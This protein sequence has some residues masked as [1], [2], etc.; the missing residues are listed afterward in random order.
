MDELAKV[1][2]GEWDAQAAGPRKGDLSLRK[3]RFTTSM[4]SVLRIEQ[5]TVELSLKQA[6]QQNGVQPGSA[7][8]Y[9]KPNDFVNLE[10]HIQ[11]R[12]RECTS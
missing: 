3:Q 9:V 6:G 7:S 12:S 2:I 8:H 11:N 10:A 1:F 5:V 4:L